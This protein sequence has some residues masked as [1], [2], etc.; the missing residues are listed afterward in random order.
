VVLYGY[1][2]WS[3]TLGEEYRLTV[4][5]NRVLRRIFGLTRNEVM[6]GWRKLH[7][8]KLHDLYSSPNKIRI[9]KPKRM[10]GEGHVA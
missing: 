10:R 3:L 2:T 7:N 1:E 4:F 8:K 5:E 9:I 6:G